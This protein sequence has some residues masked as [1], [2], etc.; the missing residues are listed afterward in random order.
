MHASGLLRREIVPLRKGFPEVPYF[1]GFSEQA[2][3]RIGLT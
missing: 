2:S 3:Y 1:M